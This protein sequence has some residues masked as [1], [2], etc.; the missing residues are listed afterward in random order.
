MPV[1]ICKISHTKRSNIC[2]TEEIQ[3]AFG[4]FNVKKRYY[5][6][7]KLHFICDENAVV[8]S[9]DFTPANV[10]DINCLK[11]VKHNINECG[12]VGDRACISADYQIDLFTNSQIKLSVPMSCN[13]LNPT[14]FSKIKCRKRK[15]IETQFRRLTD[16]F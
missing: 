1:E 16:N 11:D 9:Y 13:Q 2:Y 6:G 7:Y 5:F 14:E 3:P 8:Y 4:Y 12:L 15:R 10:H